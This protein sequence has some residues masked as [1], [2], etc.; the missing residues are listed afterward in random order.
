R[1]EIA[2]VSQRLADRDRQLA[3]LLDGAAQVSI[4]TAPEQQEASGPVDS[5]ELA[6]LRT[7]LDAR[8]TELAYLREQL[9]RADERADRYREKTES[10]QRSLEKAAAIVRRARRRSS[11]RNA[12]FTK[13]VHRLTSTR[14]RCENIEARLL[15]EMARTKRTTQIAIG[16]G[17]IAVLTLIGAFFV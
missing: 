15:Q 11:K 17:A 9:D 16:C 3:D 14:I 4:E 1:R 6:S 12:E 8:T 5:D 13:L 10:A 2:E 7:D